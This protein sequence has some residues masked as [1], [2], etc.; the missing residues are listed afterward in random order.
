MNIGII[1][2]S[3]TGHTL[4]VAQ[5]L[6]EAF[7]TLGHSVNIERVSAVNEDPQAAVKAVL[8]TIPEISGYDLLVF[9]AMVRGFSLSP[10]MNLYLTN[11]PSLEAKRVGLFVTEQ[12]PKPWMGGNRAIKQMRQACETKK[13]VIY[14]TGVINW[15]NKQRQQQIVNLIEAFT[16]L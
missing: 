9:G 16:K 15:S 13:A 4:S 8:K 2:H 12:L 1:L 7:E 14:K 10:V 5:G 11:L 6:K 3:H